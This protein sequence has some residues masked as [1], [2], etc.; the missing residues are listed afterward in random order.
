MSLPE[1]VFTFNGAE[2]RLK[3]IDLSLKG[4]IDPIKREQANLEFEYTKDIDKTKIRKYQRRIEELSLALSQMNEKKSSGKLNEK[5]TA[6]IDKLQNSFFE[7]NGQYENDNEAQGIAEMIRYHK[8]EA[9]EKA[10]SNVELIQ[11]FFETV[12]E[13]DLS[14]LD[15][16]DIKI[17]LFAMQVVSDFFFIMSSNLSESMNSKENFIN[18]FSEPEAE[19]PVN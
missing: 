11:P 1:K 12:L 6:Y 4:A 10:C 17:S 19:S 8:Q 18:Q 9:Y 5:D 3:K 16:T 2:F 15:Y 13:G 7:V 14:K